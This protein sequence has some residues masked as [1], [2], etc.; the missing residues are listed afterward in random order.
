ME[1]GAILNIIIVGVH[2]TGKSAFVQRHLTGEFKEKY[3]PS[4]ASEM[5][6]FKLHTTRG[7]L[8]FFFW[9]SQAVKE[10]DYLPIAAAIIMIDGSCGRS[11]TPVSNYQN[12][13]WYY[14]GN[15]PIAIC[16][17][18]LDL[19]STGGKAWSISDL[20]EHFDISVKSFVNCEKPL[21]WL[22]SKIFEDAQ[23]QLVPELAAY[24][25][26]KTLLSTQDRLL[27]AFY[28][29]SQPFVLPRDDE[30]DA[31]SKN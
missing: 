26:A 14:F 18:K 12:D 7:P 30:W 15:I 21:L 9:E 22:A 11:S 27:L 20:V 28:E 16:S 2:A 5:H 13:I 19:G 17:N 23:L 10:R 25:P 24:P 6:N 31:K 1:P 29:Q 8:R 3:T 4:Q